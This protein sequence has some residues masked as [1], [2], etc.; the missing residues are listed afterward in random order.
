M[1]LRNGPADTAQ[2]QPAAT[3]ARQAKGT[4]AGTPLEESSVN[5]TLQRVDMQARID[6]SPRIVSQ[7]RAVQAMLGDAVQRQ[8]NGSQTG[9]PKPLRTG[10]ES[11]SGMDMSDVQVHRNSG[12]PAQLNALA[13][14]QGKDIHLGPGQERHL[15]HEAWHVVQQRQGRVKETVQ[16]AGVGVNDDV[17]LEREADVM[18]ARALAGGAGKKQDPRPS[19]SRQLA[20][21]ASVQRT[22]APVVQ[23]YVTFD[24]R[25]QE[26]VVIGRQ[27]M[28]GYDIGNLDALVDALFG[29]KRREPEVTHILGPFLV[30]TADI[31]FDSFESAALWVSTRGREPKQG[32]AEKSL[33]VEEKK[34][35]KWKEPGEIVWAFRMEG[36]PKSP[37]QLS[38]V[39]KLVT[40][41]AAFD[42]TMAELTEDIQGREKEV[43]ALRLQWNS[44]ATKEATR[45]SENIDKFG[46]KARKKSLDVRTILTQISSK[47]DQFDSQIEQG[48]VFASRV[49]VDGSNIIPA[50]KRGGTVTGLSAGINFSV[51]SADHAS[52]FATTFAGKGGIVIRFALDKTEWRK[53][54]IAKSGPQESGIGPRPPNMTTTLNDVAQPGVKYQMEESNQFFNEVVVKSI[55]AVVTPLPKNN[56]AWRPTGE[57]LQRTVQR[58]AKA[59]LKLEQELEGSDSPDLGAERAQNDVAKQQ[60]AK[61]W[62]PGPLESL[63]ELYTA[64]NLT[65]NA[66]HSVRR[67]TGR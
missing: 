58:L 39:Q 22:A 35:E 51:G 21:A 3:A 50:N 43:E 54:K 10:I 26:K 59:Q 61:E 64:M 57:E 27:G 65:K 28:A 45:R 55:P 41:Q 34:E 38:D 16:T 25:Q 56:A 20:T 33:E 15:P 4:Q 42:A 6:R 19:P 17:G 8:G 49:Y 12:K 36:A 48:E 63:T 1:K 9:L 31:C 52:Y 14:A 46:K 67:K 2:H 11:L 62:V 23:R 47:K 37:K 18:G 24:A 60:L 7:L 53:W 44:I 5:A 13:Y 29:D 30:R 32:A 66:L 40:P